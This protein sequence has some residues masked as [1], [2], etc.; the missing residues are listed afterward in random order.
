LTDLLF[1][2]PNDSIHVEFMPVAGQTF[3]NITELKNLSIK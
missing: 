3:G 2:N 1:V